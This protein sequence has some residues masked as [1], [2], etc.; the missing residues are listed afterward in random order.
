MLRVNVIAS[1]G[2]AER[3][4]L[5]SA[6]YYLDID[7]IPARWHGQGAERLG[8]HGEVGFDQFSSL[9][10]NK[11]PFTGERLTAA[12]RSNRRIGYDFTFTAPKSVSLLA[13]M[14]GDDRIIDA[15]RKSVNETMHVIERAAAVRVRKHGDDRDRISGNLVWA[16][17]V[18]MLSR[19]TGEEGVP[20][21]ALHA[22]IVLANASFDNEEEIWK[23][24]QAGD[25]KSNAPYYQAVFRAKLAE[26]LQHL[27]Y[28]LDVKKGDFE[29]RGVPE[30]AIRKLSERTREI[31]ELARKLGIKSPAAKAKLGRTS[32]QSKNKKYSWQQLKDKW[33]AALTHDEIKAIHGTYDASYEA[34]PRF[35]ADDAAAFQ[36]ALDHLLER[37]SAVPE[38]KLLAEALRRGLGSATLEGVQAQLKRR[39]IRRGD[40]DGVTMVTTRQ[41]MEEERELIDIVRQGRGTMRPIA[42]H[43]GPECAHL[44]AGQMEA[45][46]HILQSRDR[47]AAVLGTAGTGKST[48]IA[49]AKQAI[50]QAGYRAT[51]LAPTAS[52]A[53]ITLR[54]D[55][56]TGAETLQR[57]LHDPGMQQQAAGQIVILD[58]A[59]LAGTQDMLKLARI[60]E[61]H[62]FRVA[63]LGDGRQLK[64]V[65]RGDVLA[66]LQDFGGVRATS[67]TNILRQQG[68]A[69][70]IVELL[71]SG[72]PVEAFDR[73]EAAGAVRTDGHDALAREYVAALKHDRRVCAIA[74]TH[75][76]VLSVT[77]A[78]RKAL[79]DQGM[80]AHDER[81]FPRLV[82]LQLTEAERRDAAS[83]TPGLVAQFRHAKGPFRNGEQVTVFDDNRSILQE[84][85]GAH[86]LYRLE[87]LSV[88]V[89]DRLR[90]TRGGKAVGGRRLDN[91]AAC[92]VVGFNTNGDIELSNG[93]Q[94]SRSYSHIAFDWATTVFS[95]QSRTVDTVLIASAT[96]SLA[97]MTSAAFYV[98]V[99]RARQRALVFTDCVEELRKAV[100]KPHT[101]A[102]A[103]RARIEPTMIAAAIGAAARRMRSLGRAKKEW[104]AARDQAGRAHISR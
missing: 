93:L 103:T 96:Q 13:A 34:P 71:A 99:S 65:S 66:V 14:A 9:F 1:A 64:S 46:Q 44:N 80:L 70:A 2:A 11:H 38:R 16:D 30:T 37:Q 6:D 31:E 76:E 84:L 18:H 52:A 7:G 48:L 25:I 67:V 89:G 61:Q 5:E 62:R 56:I 29:I 40:Y 63:L 49:A 85:A 12:T 45:V 19:P 98:A 102:I 41:V 24:L 21:P 101:K 32:R 100:A 60:S 8:L 35:K 82:D 97:A 27:G 81:E 58:E 69:K 22:H 43:T 72:K 87:T 15:F 54:S 39:D 73:L 17:F 74:P 20:Q 57:F 42:D 94:L 26:H 36:Y 47:F 90:I 77:T 83:Y 59:S 33:H 78:I 3:Y 95:S 88:S 28:E 91:G 68:A 53:R 51:I 4:Y 104:N 79:R 86:Q 75:A 10:R 92:S 55:G 23:A 50:E